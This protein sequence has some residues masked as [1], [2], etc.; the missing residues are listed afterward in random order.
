MWY[1]VLGGCIGVEAST[2]EV[3]AAFKT[4]VRWDTGE[5]CR[6]M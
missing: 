5:S 6:K 2:M 1:L 4:L 3:N